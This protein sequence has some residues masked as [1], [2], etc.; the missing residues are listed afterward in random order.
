MDVP[1]VTVV[2]ALAEL[3]SSSS[4]GR[5][6]VFID[7]RGREEQ[8]TSFEALANGVAERAGALLRAGLTRGDHLALVIPER[9]EFV[10]TFLGALWCG[11]IPVPLAPPIGLD[12]LSTYLER[13]RHIL[14][15]SHART[16]ITTARIKAVSG[17]LLRGS[18][19]NIVSIEELSSEPAQSIDLNPSRLGE[20]AFIQ[21][22]SGSTS[23]PRG[24][25]LTHRN[26][27][28]NCHCLA[29][30]GLGMTADDVVCSWLPFFHD[31]GL[32]GMVMAPIF[33]GSSAVYMPPLLFLKRPIE[34]LRAIGRHSGTVS[35][36]PNF[37]YGLCTK[38]VTEADL[39]DLNLSS[40]RYAGCGAEPVRMTT[41]RAF[42]Q[43]FGCV[44][45]KR[46][47]LMPGYGLAESTLAV[48]FDKG[49]EGPEYDRLDPDKLYEKGLAEVTDR[50]NAVEVACCGAPFEEHE[51]RIVDHL[52]RACADRV[53]GEIVL[54]GP[55]VM[56]GYYND[57]VATEATMK[58]GWLYTGDLGYMVDGRIYITG[59]RKEI[60]IVAGRNYYPTDI[61]HAISQLPQV[62]TGN[63]VAFGISTDD[64]EE[65]IIV[66]AETVVAA[67]EYAALADKIRGRVMEAVGLEVHD[68]LLLQAGTLPKTSSGKLQRCDVRAA[69]LAQRLAGRRA[70]DSK[71]T[72]LK[73]VARSQLHILWSKLSGASATGS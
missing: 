63:V 69:Y 5:G 18:L 27:A 64:L 30:Q 54:R 47:A 21:F 51:A 14:Q 66:C 19:H 55:S 32:I 40:W 25:V 59:R 70:R 49:E 65:K 42:A 12:H 20:T 57:S 28:V 71:L 17:S 43:K 34:W 22:T 1:Q 23:S 35:F 68:V 8:L 10:L 58:D 24:V 50:P 11:L 15:A 16:L 48:C 6:F 33:L 73:H 52:D 7:G 38:R 53:V 44:G 4:T 45:F 46:D 36:A 56:T 62:R 41:L 37:G 61:E 72:T 26:L 60:I 39:E 31:F 13:S 29:K 2:E 9:R 3:A 67:E